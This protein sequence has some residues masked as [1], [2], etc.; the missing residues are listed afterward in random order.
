MTNPAHTLVINWD[1]QG[2]IEYRDLTTGMQGM[3][4]AAER[5]C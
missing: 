1:D 3:V 5:W 2:N 4:S